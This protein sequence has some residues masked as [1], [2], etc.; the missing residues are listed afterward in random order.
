MSAITPT[1]AE[2]WIDLTDDEIA[3]EVIEEILPSIND[4]VWVAAAC[5][6]RLLDDVEAQRCL[7]RTG[8]SR[9]EEAS[10]EANKALDLARSLGDEQEPGDAEGDYDPSTLEFEDGTPELLVLRR[11]LLQRSD[12]TETYAAVCA[13]CGWSTSRLV[14]EESDSDS[15]TE[16]SSSES[17]D[18][19]EDDPWADE[20]EMPSSPASPQ[21]ERGTPPPILLSTFTLTPILDV[22]L[23]FASTLQFSALRPLIKHHGELLPHRWKILA[24]IPLYVLPTKLSGI[25][26]SFDYASEKEKL[27]DSTPRRELEWVETSEAVPILQ[28]AKLPLVTASET[29]V[30]PS[31]LLNGVEL[32]KW[33]TDR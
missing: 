25:L 23:L 11:A 8:L 30:E 1:P 29:T 18:V 5:V 14:G 13:E 7:I 9:T 17:T 6:D 31:P 2:R 12:A 4:S 27:P 24:A 19:E 10:K 20:D 16:G 26:S 28:T 32:S 3:P 21:T 33:Y 15:P 22:A